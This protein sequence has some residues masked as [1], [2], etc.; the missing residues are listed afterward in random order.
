MIT[1]TNHTCNHR[2]SAIPS[3][4]GLTQRGRKRVTWWN[5]WGEVR[6]LRERLASAEA[7]ASDWQRCTEVCEQEQNRSQD[8]CL[9]LQGK[10]FSLII[11]NSR[12]RTLL[13]NAVFRDPITGRLV[14]KGKVAA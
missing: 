4:S 10:N 14:P 2:V 13:T 11:E 7:S 12:L 3:E 8:R 6:R 5:P 9:E 1:L